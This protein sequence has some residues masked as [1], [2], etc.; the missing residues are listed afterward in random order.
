MSINIHMARHQKFRLFLK[1]LL[2]FLINNL[3]KSVS[4][5]T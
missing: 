1:N 3:I 4:E 5:Y 2:N